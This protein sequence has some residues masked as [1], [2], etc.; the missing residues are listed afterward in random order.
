[1]KV[2][3]STVLI[4]LLG[5]AVVGGGAYLLLRDRDGAPSGNDEVKAAAVTE[6]LAAS[7]N[8]QNQQQFQQMYQMMLGAL[9]QHGGDVDRAL[10]DQQLISGYVDMGVGA[11]TQI[12]TAIGS[13]AT[14]FG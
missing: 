7:L 5:L 1:M 12:A 13:L 14:A 4:G 10:R 3:G 8:V 11:A 9:K 2:K 6:D